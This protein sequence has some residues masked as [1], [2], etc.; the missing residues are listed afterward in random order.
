MSSVG[1]LASNS[2]L[3]CIIIDFGIRVTLAS[4]NEFRTDPSSSVFL[5]VFENDWHY[6]F[7]W[8]N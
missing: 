8:W 7:I 6:F 1:I 2:L 3:L 4:G 5:E